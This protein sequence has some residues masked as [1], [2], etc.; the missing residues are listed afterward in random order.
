VF[1]QDDAEHLA[2]NFPDGR[3]VTIAQAGHTVQG[4]NP[5]DLVAALREFLN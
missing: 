1:H 2:K 3:Q 5:K 4:D